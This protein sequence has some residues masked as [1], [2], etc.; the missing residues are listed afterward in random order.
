[1]VKTERTFRI[2]KAFRTI[3]PESVKDNEYEDEGW[4][5]EEGR[6]F[7][8]D[9]EGIEEAYEYLDSEG[10]GQFDGWFSTVD[11][12]TDY[13][14]GEDTWYDFFIKVDPEIPCKKNIERLLCY[15]LDLK[16]G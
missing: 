1:M 14:T 3:S 4:E 12:Q 13:Q 5:D 15:E 8:F 16:F 9:K 7:S 6:E 2:T 10:V 11:P